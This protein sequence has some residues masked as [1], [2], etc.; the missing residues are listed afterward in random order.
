V[1]DQT[2]IYQADFLNINFGIPLRRSLA[3]ALQ[4]SLLSLD[5]MTAQAIAFKSELSFLSSTSRVS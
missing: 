5:M 1:R 2:E 3:T 4:T